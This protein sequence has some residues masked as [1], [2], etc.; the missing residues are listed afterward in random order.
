M[1]DIHEHHMPEILNS[2][3]VGLLELFAQ[4]YAG[5]T[6]ARPYPLP[7]EAAAGYT[8]PTVP[9]GAGWDDVAA[10]VERSG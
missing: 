10:Y 9:E 6:H 5:W 7:S 1:V 2:R 3:E 4:S 8:P